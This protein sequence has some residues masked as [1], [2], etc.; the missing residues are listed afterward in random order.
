[1][2]MKAKDEMTLSGSAKALRL[3]RSQIPYQCVSGAV[4]IPLT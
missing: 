4:F 3:E 2:I 1:V